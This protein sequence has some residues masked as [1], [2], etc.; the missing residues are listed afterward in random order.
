MKTAYL[1]AS[2]LFVVLLLAGCSVFPLGTPCA[3]VVTYSAICAANPHASRYH[4]SQI[5]NSRRHVDSRNG[6]G[7][8]GRGHD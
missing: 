7:S 1:V 8:R 3:E 6:Y 4:G 5:S 2:E